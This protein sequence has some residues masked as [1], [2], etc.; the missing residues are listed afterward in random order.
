MT[1]DLRPLE[2]SLP[3][4]LL[5]AREAAMSRFRPILAPY[6]ITDQ[7]WRVLRALDAAP[8]ASVGDLARRACLLG[9]SVSRMLRTMEAEGWIARS[10]DCADARRSLITLAPAGRELVDVI[11]PASEHAARDLEAALGAERLDALLR[12]LDE[13]ARTLEDGDEEAA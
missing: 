5:R 6:G 3:I 9:P 11:T 1:S 2:R 10:P 8:A 4:A 13:L 7:Q 12:A